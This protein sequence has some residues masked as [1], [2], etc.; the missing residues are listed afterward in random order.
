MQLNGYMVFQNR[1]Q[2]CLRVAAYIVGIALFCAPAMVSAASLYFGPTSGSYEVGEQFSV[3]VFVSSDDAELNAIKS[4]VIAANSNVE[5]VSISQSN[6]IIDFWAVG[7][8]VVNGTDARFEGVMLGRGYQ[9]PSAN[10]VTLIYRGRS[11]GDVS[12]S[13]ADS[14][15]LANDGFGTELPT[16]VGSAS[17]SIT[18]VP[19]VFEV[20]PGFVFTLDLETGA[21]SAEV[22]YLQICLLEQGLFDGAVTGF[23]GAET[24]R[25]VSAFQELYQD[26]ILTPQGFTAGTGIVAEMTRN[27][28]NEICF[29]LP[30]VEEA[31]EPEPAPVE[32]PVVEAVPE[33]VEEVAFY[34]NIWFWISVCILLLIIIIILLLIIIVLLTRRLPRHIEERQRYVLKQEGAT[35][36][37]AQKHLQL[38]KAKIERDLSRIENRLQKIEPTEKALPVAGTKPA[39]SRTAKKMGITKKK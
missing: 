23:F 16:T 38:S 32:E 21:G 14:A 6:S 17:F 18:P 37:K 4:D 22:A 27:K 13:F 30:I 2:N 33:V 15:V 34:E 1:T 29:P 9:G 28:L 11:V 12:L 10:V 8:T 20:P 26:D 31:P 19:E 39:K 25:A 5:L 24:K 7:P 35:L 36:R 3:N